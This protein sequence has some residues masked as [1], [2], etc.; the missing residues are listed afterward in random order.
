[1]KNDKN[2]IF[3][4]RKIAIWKLNGAKNSLNGS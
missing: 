4:I 2:N 3:V 1:M